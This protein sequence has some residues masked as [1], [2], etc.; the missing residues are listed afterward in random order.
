LTAFVP[1]RAGRRALLVLSAAAAVALGVTALMG[2][3]AGYG[4]LLGALKAANPMWVALA[5]PAEALAYVG[6]ALAFRAA[7]ALERGPRLGLTLATRVVAASVGAT[8][9]MLGGGPG[10]LYWA[11]RRTGMSKTGSIARLVALNVLLFGVLGALVWSASL[12]ALLGPGAPLLRAI[13]VPWLVGGAAV[14]GGLSV[15]VVMF[16]MRLPPER[17]TTIVRVL[18]RRPAQHATAY[19]G[20]ALYWAGDILCLWLALRAFDVTLSFTAL[21]LA[22][23]TSYLATMLPLPLGGAG[24]GEAAITL[25]LTAVG[26]P[27]APALVGV[28]TYRLFSFWLPTLPGLVLLA[29]GPWLMRGLGRS[30]SAPDGSVRPPMSEGPCAQRI[31]A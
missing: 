16:G 25:A 9:L 18:F 23:A 8:R 2:M 3:A 31:D 14:G 20:A 11:L 30:G 17:T 1:P 12:L 5:L 7:A 27:L 26:V 19:V 22:Y 29:G 15:A 28:L 10:Y 21:V 13:A 24:G 6:Y 4:R